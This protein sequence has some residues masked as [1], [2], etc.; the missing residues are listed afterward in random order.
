[1]PAFWVLNNQFQK[2][3]DWQY[4]LDYD[5]EMTE[6]LFAEYTGIKIKQFRETLLLHMGN[7]K[8]SLAERTRHKRQYDIRM[9]ERHM[10]SRESKVVLSKVL[11]ASLVVTECSGIKS[12]EYI[13]SSS[14]GTYI[15]H[16]VDADISLVNDQVPSV[17]VHLNA[18]H[19]V[20]ANEQ[21]HTDQSELIYDTHLL[22]TVNSNTTPDS[23][24]ISHRGGEID[25]DAEQDQVYTYY[26]QV[27][28]NI[29]T[30]KL[31]TAGDGWDGKKIIITEASIRNDLRLDDAEGT[32][33]SGVITHLFETIMVQAPEEVGE[34]PNDTQ[35]IP[36]LTQPSSSQP[37]KKNK[38][39]R[40]QRKETKVPHTKPQTEE[41]IPTPS[42]DPIPSA[43]IKKLKKR[44]KKLERKKKKRNH[45]LKRL[46]KEEEGLGDQED[47]SKQGRI[48]EI[49]VDDDLSLINKTTQ[50]QGRMN[51]E[52]LFGV[53]DLDGD[54]V[55]D[56]NNGIKSK[57]NRTKPSTKRK[58]WKSQKSTKVNKKSNQTKS[59]PPNQQVKRNELEGL[60]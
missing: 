6:K 45:G 48:A 3:I 56:I 49:D 7:V 54:E 33:F 59:K 53:N 51:D 35:D 23:T 31:T 17:E 10:Q 39:R 41:H 27:K 13:T 5:S 47:A 22:E 30:H 60:K 11:D 12:D 21:Q 37:Q 40:K 18:Q 16:V 1:M 52:D 29:A 8:K 24:N 25:Q 26:C 4:L 28:V 20:L 44:V 36:I 46:Y 15:T 58:A 32:G 14:L 42:N 19:N 38:S 34:I 55:T 9:K 2:F 50:D 43:E 57:Q